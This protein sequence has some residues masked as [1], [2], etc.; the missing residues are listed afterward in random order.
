MRRDTKF[1]DLVFI[2]QGGNTNFVV[3]G[4]NAHTAVFSSASKFFRELFVIAHEKQPYEQIVINLDS[5]DPIVFEKLIEYMYEGRTMVNGKQKE[6]LV[7]LCNTLQLDIPL[8]HL[9]LS[10]Q[11]IIENTFSIGEIVS[12]PHSISMT[13]L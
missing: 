4:I 6:E 9:E 8:Q 11:L 1:S 13:C 7:I 10:S 3:K 5:V 2:C 12:E